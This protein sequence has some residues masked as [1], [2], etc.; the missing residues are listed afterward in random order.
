MILN[1]KIICSKKKFA[2]LDVCANAQIVNHHCNFYVVKGKQ[3]LQIF[4]TFSQILQAQSD[5]KIKL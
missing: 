1:K 5:Q 4:P 2:I 3:V